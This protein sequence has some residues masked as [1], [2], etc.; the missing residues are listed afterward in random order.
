[1]LVCNVCMCTHMCTMYIM[2]STTPKTVRTFVKQLPGAATECAV[3]KQE[4][5]VGVGTGTGEI[6]GRVRYFYQPS[7]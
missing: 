6:F 3:Q 1:M 2:E 5:I 4:L 7:S